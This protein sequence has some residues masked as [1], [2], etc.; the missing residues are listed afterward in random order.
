MKNISILGSTG[1]IGQNTLDIVR[2]NPDKL[3]V[4]NISANSNIDLLAQQVEE[5][6]P[7]HVVI[8][9]SSKAEEAKAKL[10]GTVLEFGTEALINLAGEQVDLLIN[11]LVGASGVLPTLEAIKTGNQIALANKETLITAGTVVTQKAKEKNVRIFPIDSEHSA[12][13]QCLVG[14]DMND[15]KYIHVTASGGPFR[16]RKRNELE[17]VTVDQAL[18]HPNWKMGSKITID[19]ATLMNKGFEVIETFWLY[20]TDVNQIKV[21][22]HPQSIIHSMVEFKDGSFKAQLGVPDMRV[23]IQYAISYPERWPLT[24]APLNFADL[25]K[26]DFEDADLETFKCLKLAYDSLRMSGTM[27]AV[28]NAA[29]EITNR[30]FLDKEIRFNQIGD[31]NEDVMNQHKN[32]SDPDIDTILDA[33]NWARETAREIIEKNRK[34]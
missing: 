32:C 24:V 19:S 31:I 27:P 11:A 16:G 9:D 26:L 5:F 2:K 7:D 17:S 3:R 18:A 4:K 30:A 10:N 6:K 14:E 8:A 1:S 13:W 20:G 29:N 23:P 34:K 25:K 15:I 28:L 22:V 33:D 12:I 21:I